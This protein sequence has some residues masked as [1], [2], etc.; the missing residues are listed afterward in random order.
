MIHVLICI[1]S[2]IILLSLFLLRKKYNFVTEEKLLKVRK[3]H[4][5]SM[6]KIGGACLLPVL[7]IVFYGIDFQLM[8]VVYSSILVFLIGFIDDL[9]ESISALARLIILF[10]IIFLFISLSGLPIREIGL[11]HIDIYLYKFSLIA[12]I[13]TTLCLLV[14]INGFNLID[15]QHG[16]MLGTNFL[17][18][19]SF[20]FLLPSDAVLAKNVFISLLIVTSILFVANY[21]TGK[22]KAGDCGSYFL[23]FV[24]GSLVIYSYNL[25]TID[26]FFV[27][28]LFFYPVFELVFSYFRRIFTGKNPFKPDDKHLHSLL[29]SYLKNSHVLKSVDIEDVNR[30]T[31][32]IILLYLA[33]LYLGLI[34]FFNEIN[35]KIVFVS[36]FIV[37]LFFYFLFFFTTLYA[38]KI[39]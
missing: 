28:C 37:Y 16:L 22:I 36:M 8:L 5:K 10:T 14:T 4:Q 38:K 15:G 39:K 24:T 3:I 17:I 9:N 20:Y 31:S 23:G 30:L 13:F 26:P 29:F 2:L 34:I 6:I 18:V 35:Y 21:F 32:F 11:G 1:S 7:L 25:Y 12:I 27:A 33:L 19:I